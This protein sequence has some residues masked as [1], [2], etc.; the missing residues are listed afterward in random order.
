MPMMVPNGGAI[1]EGVKSEEPME[2]GKKKRKKRAYKPRDPNAPKR[3]LTA[4]FRYLGEARPTI[5]AEINT[6]PELHKTTG[7][8]GDISRIATDRWNALTAEQQQPYKE[9]YQAELKDY[10]KAIAAYKAMGGQVDETTM[11]TLDGAEAEAA[12]TPAAV[13]APAAE[14]AAEEE[15]DDDDDDTT[16]DDD[17]EEE[18]EVAPPPPPQPPKATPKKSA[19]KKGGK[20][21]AVQ[22]AP[23]PAVSTATPIFSSINNE[24][25]AG[26]PNTSSDPAKSSS[27][28]RKRKGADATVAE[29]ESGRKKRTRKSNAAEEV[30]A[31]ADEAPAPAPVAPMASSP[32]VADTTGKKKK[33]KKKRRGNA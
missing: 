10:E 15:E 2:G 12:A 17:D 1:A 19:L 7:K 30:V 32:D 9:A 24:A 18:E 31:G 20:A 11:M 23:A 21:S 26:V 16:S 25:A 29:G 5:Q 14:K 8:P 3:P 13:M 33:D 27:P 22:P 4:Y 28:T 6:N